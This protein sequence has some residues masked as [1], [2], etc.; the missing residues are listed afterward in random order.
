MVKNYEPTIISGILTI[1][2]GM[3]TRCF[4]SFQENT[5]SQAGERYMHQWTESWLVQIVA[6]LAPSH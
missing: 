3:S 2:Y 6:C 1:K 5:L 4:L